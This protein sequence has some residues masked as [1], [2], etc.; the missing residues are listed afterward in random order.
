LHPPGRPVRL[1]VE[2]G[3]TIL[4]TGPAQISLSD[5][6]AEC[7]GAPI[8]SDSWITVEALR[9]EPILATDLAVFAIKLRPGGSWREVHESTIPTGWTEAA[10]VLQRQQ[11]VAVIIGDV[12]SGKS[13]LCTFLANMC[14]Q[15]GL[16]VA[17]I[18][19]DVGQ[20]DIGPPATVSSSRV[21]EPILS[22]QELR[23]ETAFFVGDT[24]PS[25]VPDKLI[26]SLVRLKEDLVRS[27]DVLI[28][29]TDGWVGDSAALRFKDEM[30]Y[31]T[32]PDLVIGLSRGAENDP[33]LERVSRATL[34]LSSSIYARIR[35][36]EERKKA[37]EAGYRRFL[38]SP[39]TLKIRQAKTRLRMFDRP[40]LQLLR[41]DRRFKGFLVGLLD[42]NQELLGIGR[43]REMKDGDAIVETKTLEQPRFLEIGNLVLSS[44]YEE[45]GYG[46]LH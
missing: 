37:R 23:Q 12:D 31:E 39:K 3:H 16:R 8:K 2:Q 20:A 28:V 15:D 11:G 6:K 38:L 33:L 14:V 42:D 34:R 13:S 32:Q 30:L 24:S 41:W 27:T 5:G 18:D 36:K 4:L 19:A 22:L 26:R 21:S 25:S 44:K 35:S 43:V 10:H 7:F 17:V 45:I 9:Q 46:I 40:E 29:N 1:R